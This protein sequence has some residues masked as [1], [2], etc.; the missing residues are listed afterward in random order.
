MSPAVEYDRNADAKVDARWIND[1]HGVA[2]RY[3]VDDNF[4]GR[5]KWRFE[6]AVGRVADSTLDSNGDGKPDSVSHLEHGVLR[7]IDVYDDGGRRIVARQHF[8][9]GA[10][11]DS[12][13]FDDDGDGT[14]ERHIDFDRYGEPKKR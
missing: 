11:N 7:S 4:D 10:W 5:F 1:I 14:F 12:T 8:I 9:Y 13:E 3:E 2:S 6:A